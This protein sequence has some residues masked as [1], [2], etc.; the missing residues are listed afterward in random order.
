MTHTRDRA[1]L[2]VQR[3]VR[4]YWN[5]SFA[6][7]FATY[8]LL[9][10]Q[11]SVRGYWN[12]GIAVS[13]LPLERLLVQRSVRG[14]W[15]ALVRA[16]LEMILGYLFNDPLED[17]EILLCLGGWRLWWRLL[18]QRSVRGYWNQNILP[19]P[20]VSSGYLFNDPLEDTEMHAQLY[21]PMQYGVTCSTIR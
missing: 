20:P 13:F 11:R 12:F 16:A 14:Y 17:T 21:R 6:L 3:S 8:L 10:V 1:W 2:L 18:V 5:L 19:P 7:S 9:L 4:G 15:N